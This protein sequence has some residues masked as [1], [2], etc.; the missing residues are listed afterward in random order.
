MI[1]QTLA[2]VARLSPGARRVGWRVLYEYLARLDRG[3]DWAFMNYGF[4]NLDPRAAPLVLDPADEP[5]RSCIQLYHHV[6]GAVDLRGRDVLEVGCGRGGGCSYVRRYL[7]PRA[8]V[9]V[10]LSRRAVNLCTRHH[11]RPGLSF[12]QGDAEALPVEDNGFDVVIN[13]ESSHCYGS[14]PRF[15][16]EVRRV[17]RPGGYFLFADLRPAGEVAQ[18]RGHLRTSGL[19]VLQEETITPGVLAALA[20]DSERKRVLI[21]RK[22]PRLIRHQIRE[23]AGLAG[24]TVYEDFRRGRAEYLRFVL[25][26][27]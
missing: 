12:R 19:D 11:A 22:A 24:T 18:L 14:M 26:K 7:Q 9:G 13:V 6:A 25:R 16:A 21:H 10:D 23:F 17:L 4:V 5:E 15:L 20:R 2:L 8:V 27:A 3:A 1:V